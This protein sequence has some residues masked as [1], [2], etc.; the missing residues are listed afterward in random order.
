MEQQKENVFATLPLLLAAERK[1]Q[2]R[3]INQFYT[4]FPLSLSTAA[5]F[6]SCHFT[7][8]LSTVATFHFYFPQMPLQKKQYCWQDDFNLT[9]NIC[10]QCVQHICFDIWTQMVW[11]FDF[12]FHFYIFPFRHSHVFEAGLWALSLH[13]DI[14]Q[15][16]DDLWRWIKLWKCW[17]NAV[18]LIIKDKRSEWASGGESG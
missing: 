3:A 6:Y 11:H 15:V 16:A 13:N 2:R 7:L 5:S 12:L 10:V 18:F 4:Q 9:F 17:E 8:S 14:P 1:T